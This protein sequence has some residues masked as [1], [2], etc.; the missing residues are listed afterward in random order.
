MQTTT[1][2]PMEQTTMYPMQT[3]TIMPMESTIE[4]NIGLPTGL[5]F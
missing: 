3:T 2:M 4:P 1:M 5:P